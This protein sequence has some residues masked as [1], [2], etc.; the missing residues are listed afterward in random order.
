MVLLAFF[1]DVALCDRQYGVQ[2]FVTWRFN[3][4]G[5]F[6][7]HYADTKENA[8]AE[9]KERINDAFTSSPLKTYD[10]WLNG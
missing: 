4:D 10:N 7:G 2:P 9:F 1:G 6:W 5:F 3:E 8:M